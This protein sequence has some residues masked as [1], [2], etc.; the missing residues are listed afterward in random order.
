MAVRMCAC[1]PWL[2]DAVCVLRDN[3]MKIRHIGTTDEKIELQMTPMI[4]IVFQLLIFFIMTFK[5]VAQEGDFNI[6]MPLASSAGGAA[7]REPDS[8]DA[9]SAAG[10]CQRQAALPRVASW[11]MASWCSIPSMNCTTT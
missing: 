7:G 6:K 10:R 9:R 4:D 8:D 11:S 1:V 3:V 5:I 2:D